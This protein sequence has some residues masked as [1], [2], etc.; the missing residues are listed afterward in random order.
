MNFRPLTVDGGS[1]S[2]SGGWNG[3]QGGLRPAADVGDALHVVS[4]NVVSQE[5]AQVLVIFALTSEN[6]QLPQTLFTRTT[7]WY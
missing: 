6:V 5:V 3:G 1:L 4:V 2:V 7:I